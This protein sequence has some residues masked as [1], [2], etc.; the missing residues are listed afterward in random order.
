MKV[1]MASLALAMLAE[2]V[3]AR[4]CTDGLDYCGRSLNSIGDYQ[5]DME[6]ECFDHA[7]YCNGD[8][9]NRV[10]FKC[11]YGFFH[12]TISV[13]EACQDKCISGGAGKSD[14]CEVY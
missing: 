3:V 12:N 13:K 6:N 1:A 8:A 4:Y 14:Y 5:I 11:E 7:E 10:L 2:A 9:V